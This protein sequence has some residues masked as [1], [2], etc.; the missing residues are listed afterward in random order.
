MA[1]S[2]LALNDRLR[3]LWQRARGFDVAS[4]TERARKTA[5]IHGK[6]YPLVLVDMLWS[7]A[8]HRVGFNDYMEFDFAILTRAER[9]TW[10]TSPLALELSKRYDDPAYVH[11][12]HHKTD[13]NRLFDRYLG[14]EW[15]DLETAGPDEL[16]A[17]AQ[18]HPVLI[19]KE[20]VSKS[21]FGVSRYD[22]TEVT[23]WAALHA[24][25][26]QRGQ[27]LVEERIE[28]HPTLEAIAPGTANTTRV[29]TFVKDDGTV[30]IV[31]MAQKFGRGKVSDQGA[32]GGFYTALHE[33][34]RAM[35]MG[36]DIHGE[37]YAT[38]PDTG[39]TIADFQLPDM[40]A[41]RALI[42]E[43]ALVV[44]QVR[45]VGWDIVATAKGPVLVEGN[46]GA[47]VFENKPT[48]TGI[49]H[50]HLPRYRAAMG[51]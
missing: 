34:G 45:Y 51:F 24:E 48:A 25:L 32:F 38:H 31:N 39:A 26:V 27:T 36:Y 4:V 35:G 9:A 10:V 15:L 17:F 12:F 37:L 42:T 29:T 40:D 3:F 28:Q 41:V 21:G 22:T 47:G 49:R 2:G 1:S 11:H 18:R 20:P 46:W 44:P 13:F 50:G 6:S 14:R 33:D 7:A 23:D 5:R 43:V 30:E 8:R 16:R 19:G